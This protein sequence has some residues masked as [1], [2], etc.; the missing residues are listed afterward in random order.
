M[1]M[2]I[3][4]GTAALREQEVVLHEE[5]IRGEVRSKA[6][7]QLKDYEEDDNDDYHNDDDDNENYVEQARGEVCSQAKMVDHYNEFTINIIVI[8]INNSISFWIIIIIIIIIIHM[9]KVTV[10][11]G[12]PRVISPAVSTEEWEV[13]LRSATQDIRK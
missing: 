1:T 8:I 11:I 10:V 12:R 3:L 7:G 4:Q 5:Q 9:L 2:M 6:G 13:S